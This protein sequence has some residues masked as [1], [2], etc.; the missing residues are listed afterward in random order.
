MRLASKSGRVPAV[1]QPFLVGVAVLG[2][3]RRDSVGVPD[4]EPEPGRRAVIEDV[5]GIVIEADHLGEAID[6]LRDPVEGMAA[7]RHVGP[8]E[9][10]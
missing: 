6:C 8:S 5:D 2:D 3:D 1:A 10:R 9:A 4:G 7:A